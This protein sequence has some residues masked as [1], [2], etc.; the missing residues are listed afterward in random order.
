MNNG[1]SNQEMQNYLN[2]I[3]EDLYSGLN[4]LAG[5]VRGAES[6]EEIAGQLEQLAFDICRHWPIC[7]EIH[8]LEQ[9]KPQ[10]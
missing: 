1:M 2:L 5:R 9:S 8:N 10:N 7:A 6:P 4:N 3:V